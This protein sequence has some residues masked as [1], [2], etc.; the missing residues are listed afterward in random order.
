MR[1]LLLC[2]LFLFLFVCVV[3]VGAYTAG[4]DEFTVINARPLGDSIFIFD[5]DVPGSTPISNFEITQAPKH[6]FFGIDKFI[7]TNPLY[8]GPDSFKYRVWDGQWSNEAT[9]YITVVSYGTCAVRTW[10]YTP[11]NTKLT[12]DTNDYLECH[13]SIGGKDPLTRLI[14]GRISHGLLTPIKC[15]RG[16]NFNDGCFEYTPD[17]GFN[18]WDTFTFR[19]WYDTF[20]WGDVAGEEIEV[21]IYVGQE[22]YPTQEFPSIFLPAIMIIGFVGVLLHLR[23]TKEN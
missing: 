22:P 19:P 7:T 16:N 2:G 18:G 3:P 8:F 4:H 20:N 6:G 17:S 11:T 15:Q 1:K 13:P 9:V 5:N 23:K 10:L 14:S 21:A 12:V